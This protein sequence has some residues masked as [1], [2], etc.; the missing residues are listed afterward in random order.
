M[1]ISLDYLVKKYNLKINSVLHV[2]AHECEEMEFYLN[3]NISIEDVIWVEAQPQIVE[4]MKMYNPKYKIFNRAISDENNKEIDFIVT[5]NGQSSSMLE[6]GEHKKY[7]PHVFESY[8]IKMKTSTLDT[9]IE[10]ENIDMT[11][12]NFL[13]MDI[14]GAELLALKGM[15]NNLKYI[16]Y[17]YLEV[18]DTYIYENCGL[19][20]EIDEFLNNHGFSR[21]ETH[22]TEF[23]WGDAFFIKI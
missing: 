9:F 11:K 12:V 20:A 19:I 17:I 5:N 1:L 14:Q 18:N 15:P 8:R 2:G 22:M 6:L 7:H 21:V 13:N 10:E 3:N 16:D 4:K 23:H